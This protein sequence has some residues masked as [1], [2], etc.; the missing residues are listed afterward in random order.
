MHGSMTHVTFDVLAMPQSQP[1]LNYLHQKTKQTV[2]NP[3]TQ[4]TMATN[5]KDVPSSTEQPSKR[6]RLDVDDAFSSGEDE[7]D[8]LDLKAAV[9]AS[10]RQLE[11]LEQTVSISEYQ[12]PGDVP[13]S[14]VTPAWRIH[15]YTGAST[16]TIDLTLE[17]DTRSPFAQDTFNIDE[18]VPYTRR[19]FPNPHAREGASPTSPAE[20]N[21]PPHRP[22]QDAP[23]EETGTSPLQEVPLRS[24][25]HIQGRA[26][27]FSH[28]PEST[29]SQGPLAASNG[30][31]SAPS[32]RPVEIHVPTWPP[33]E[34][35]QSPT[36]AFDETF[37]KQMRKSKSSGPSALQK[38]ISRTRPTHLPPK[39]LEEDVKHQKDWEEMMRL[40]REAGVYDIRHQ[41]RVSTKIEK[42][43]AKRKGAL[44]MRRLER[45]RA[46]EDTIPI[47]ER[48]VV[49]DWRNALRE[50]RLRKLWWNGIP[51]KLRGQMWEQAVGNALQLSKGR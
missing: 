5:S 32:R 15:A 48:E 20:E 45:E 33:P 10:R 34:P 27:A 6:V 16:S 49:P 41:E 47:W 3:T 13:P 17:P 42:L 28:R 51:T 44:E 37:K 11:E 2:F 30:Q 24:S 21:S 4:P 39:P 22:V 25:M 1:G 35:P 46:V 18:D 31:H 23:T 7:P 9:A 19:S 38:V 14:T 29:A 50:P 12:Q 26:L 36:S 40:S 8:A 43:D